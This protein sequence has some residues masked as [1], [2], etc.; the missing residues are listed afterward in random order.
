VEAPEQLLELLEAAQVA[1]HLEGL[2]QGIAHAG[3]NG[4]WS[5]LHE[6]PCRSAGQ[7]LHAQIPF[8]HANIN[9]VWPV[10]LQSLR[11]RMK[12]AAALWYE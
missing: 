11:G 12:Q 5:H 3:V 4:G 8:L 1:I 10:Q 6:P 2:A 9:V 7:G